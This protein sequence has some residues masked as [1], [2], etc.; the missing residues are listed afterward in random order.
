M[1]LFTGN[2]NLVTF[3]IYF[4]NTRRD[5]KAE[6]AY[7]IAKGQLLSQ[8][9]QAYSFISNLPDSPFRT[10]ALAQTQ[11]GILSLGRAHE[12]AP[13]TSESSSVVLQTNVTVHPPAPPAPP[14]RDDQFV[15]QES[16]PA[17]VENEDAFEPIYCGVCQRQIMDVKGCSD[18]DSLRSLF[19]FSMFAPLD[20][21]SRNMPTLQSKHEHACPSQF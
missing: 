20:G 18:D 13:V 3:S 4:E 8:Q 11:S 14:V 2:H 6:A 9:I 15:S 1:K 7:M 21:A 12:V 16:Q 19:P 5:K 17:Y 10:R